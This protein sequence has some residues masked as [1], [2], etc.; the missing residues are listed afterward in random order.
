MVVWSSVHSLADGTTGDS[1]DGF[2]LSD[3]A[4]SKVRMLIAQCTLYDMTKMSR[5]LKCC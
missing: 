3:I 1:M 4:T 5:P 2:H